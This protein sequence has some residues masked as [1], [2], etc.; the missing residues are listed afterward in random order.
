MAQGGR[1]NG[2]KR[3]PH[4]VADPAANKAEY[5]VKDIVGHTMMSGVKHWLVQWEGYEEDPRNNTYEPVENL[6]GCE[7]YI[8]RYERELKEK[9]A[10]ADRLAKQKEREKA[11]AKKKAEEEAAALAEQP[12]D[13][14]T[15]AIKE[16]L[17]NPRQCRRKSWAWQYFKPSK[18]D[19]AFELCQ[20][21][22]RDDPDRMCLNPVKKCRGPSPF[23][24]KP[25]CVCP[26]ECLARAR[27]PG[28]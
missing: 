19:P 9:T 5:E 8:A 24:I 10:E 16:H 20:L 3:T 25:C 6:A 23:R 22:H 14:D 18:V 12:D 13:E 4:T 11:E 17:E 2:Q 26:Q 15:E 7:D 21:P 27:K 28:R 1:G